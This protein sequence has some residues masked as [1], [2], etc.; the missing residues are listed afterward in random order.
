MQ[1]QTN[2][3]RRGNVEIVVHR[4]VLDDQARRKQEENIK[5][6]LVCMGKA[7]MQQRK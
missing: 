3:Y 1:Y 5:R 7:M 2:T 6:A 4:P